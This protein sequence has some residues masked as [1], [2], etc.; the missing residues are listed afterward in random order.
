VHNLTSTELSVDGATARYSTLFL[1]QIPP[2]RTG[3]GPRWDIGLLL[4]VVFACLEQA[5]FYKQALG[6]RLIALVGVVSLTRSTLPHRYQ[7][8]NLLLRAEVDANMLMGSLSQRLQEEAELEVLI[9][10][11]ADDV[12]GLSFKCLLCKR[13]LS[14]DGPG[15]P[16]GRP[17]APTRPRPRA[18]GARGM[19]SAVE[20]PQ[21]GDP[22]G[23]SE[24]PTST[25]FS[26]QAEEVA[27][28]LARPVPGIE[29][30]LVQRAKFELL[31]AYD[32]LS[33]HVDSNPTS[34]TRSA[35]SKALRE[36]V[37]SFDFL[38]DADEMKMTARAVLAS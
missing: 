25:V 32:A 29:S 17:K 1:D 12:A 27:E 13:I 15:K 6:Q 30:A 23:A 35:D 10:G 7:L 3:T 21:S 19:E 9:A 20:H 26:L 31:M 2:S 16:K 34:R 24:K 33:L 38:D 18:R 8:A 28:L 5:D 11:C 36:L 4:D 14:A 37:T 22:D